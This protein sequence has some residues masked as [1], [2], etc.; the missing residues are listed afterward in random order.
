MD[1]M[2]TVLISAALVFIL[3]H[4]NKKTSKLTWALCGFVIR[5]LLWRPLRWL[6]KG[7]R[8]PG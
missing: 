2:R 1:S 8:L 6:F 3:A 7:L 5:N 4:S